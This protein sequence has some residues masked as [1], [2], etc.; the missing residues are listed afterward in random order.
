MRITLKAFVI[1]L[2]NLASIAC[3]CDN[4]GA[5]ERQERIPGNREVLITPDRSSGQTPGANQRVGNKV[6]RVPRPDDLPSDE[7]EN[8]SPNTIVVRIRYK[9]ELGRNDQNGTKGQFTCGSFY[10]RTT[11][12]DRE[13]GGPFGSPTPL[14]RITAHSLLR[15]GDDFYSC[16]FSVTELPFNKE[17]TV[18]G[19]LLDEQQLLTKPWTDGSQSQPPPGY[20]R[21]VVGSRAVTLTPAQPSAVVDLQM[22]YVPIQSGPR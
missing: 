4:A 16:I 2:C 9:K 10:V 1:I 13:R 5:Q 14:G 21:T 8:L 20:R 12:L 3:L 7:V 17:I 22:V 19:S 6:R 15:E 11:H 18:Y